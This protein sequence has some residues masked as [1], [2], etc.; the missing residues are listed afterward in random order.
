MVEAESV[1]LGITLVK[2]GNQ[3]EGV[4]TEELATISER[5]MNRMGVADY[6]EPGTILGGDGS[7]MEEAAPEALEIIS[8]AAGSPMAEVGFVA[9]EITSVEDGS[10]GKLESISE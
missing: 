3:T 10:E 4:D 1:V 5:A 9:P 2:A 6:G 7:L 8:A